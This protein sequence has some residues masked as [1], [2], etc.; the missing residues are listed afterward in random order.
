MRIVFM[1]TPD[2]AVKGLETIHQAGHEIPLVISQEDKAKDRKGNILKTPVKQ[3]AESLG[4]PVRSVIRLRK[5]A[6]LLSHLKDLNPDCIV[7]A[8]FGQILPKE[9]L[10]L[11]RYGC[12]NIHASLLPLYRGAS[13]IQQAILNRDKETGISTMLMAEGLDTGDI[14]LQKK[15]PLTGEETGES[16]FE[17]LALLSQDCILE[18]LRLLEEGKCPR[19]AQEEEK[20]SHC[21]MILKQDG[22]V[23]WNKPAVEIEAMVRAFNPWPAAVS[24]LSNGKSFK[25]WKARVVDKLEEGFRSFSEIQEE[26]LFAHLPD[27]LSEEKKEAFRKKEGVG[28]MY[29]NKENKRLLLS[30]GEGYLEILEIQVEGKKRMDTP[31][32]LLGFGG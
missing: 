15:L 12:V 6:E 17:A 2:F 19:R 20:A 32:F 13:P 23:N 31:A 28:L 29:K 10:E 14:L 21:S 25:I 7:V 4:L 8:A 26:L 22:F 11:P 24:I 30:T 27:S 9:V 1:G 5:D 3:A 16:L 18:T